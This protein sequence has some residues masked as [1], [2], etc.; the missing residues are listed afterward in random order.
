MDTEWVHITSDT[1]QKP[2]QTLRCTGPTRSKRVL[3][4]RL[5][6]V[7]RREHRSLTRPRLRPIGNQRP[8]AAHAEDVEAELESH[9]AYFCSRRRAISRDESHSTYQ[10]MHSIYRP[11]HLQARLALGARRYVRRCW[12]VVVC[13]R[14]RQDACSTIFSR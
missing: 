2:Q 4:D 7:L 12:W 9:L 3:I 6:D 13:S 10:T 1:S 11:F 14:S 5:S 8:P